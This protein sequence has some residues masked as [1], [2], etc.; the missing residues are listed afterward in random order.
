MRDKDLP[1]PRP[2]EP[3][4]PLPGQTRPLHPAQVGA[5]VT[6]HP[7]TRRPVPAD[8]PGAFHIERLNAKGLLHQVVYF[9]C[10]GGKVCHFYV[11]ATRMK[12]PAVEWNGAPSRLTC[13][14]EIECPAHLPNGGDTSNC[15]WAGTIRDGVM[16]TL[17]EPFHETGDF[18]TPHQRTR[19]LDG[20]GGPAV[21]RRRRHHPAAGEQESA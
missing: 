6:L 10:P 2:A 20:L 11:G 12:A 13:G 5:K 17:Q 8:P 9:R 14:P 4:L 1:H 3:G 18:P 21:P 15:G 7:L 16:T 19:Y